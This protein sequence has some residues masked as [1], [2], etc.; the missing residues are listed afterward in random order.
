MSDDFLLNFMRVAQDITQAARGVGVDLEMKIRGQANVDA[1][2]LALPEFQELVVASVEEAV[3]KGEP[4]LKNNM[5]QDV[6]EAP[7]T[8]V[9][10]TDLRMILA[11]PLDGH[12]AIYLDLPVKQGIFER[13]AIDKLATLAQQVIGN[14]QTNLTTEEL[15][16]LY[17]QL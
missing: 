15:R 4:V 14:N 13:A 2:V 5:I 1:E 16:Q 6:S 9:H 12:G 8:N 11:L 7:Q 17:T 3:E 10:L